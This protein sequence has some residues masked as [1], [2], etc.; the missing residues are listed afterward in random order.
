ML[1]AD[2]NVKNKVTKKGISLLFCSFLCQFMEFYLLRLLWPAEPLQV[3]NFTELS[4]IPNQAIEHHS[5]SRG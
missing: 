2:A 1:H 5:P 4:L 3:H